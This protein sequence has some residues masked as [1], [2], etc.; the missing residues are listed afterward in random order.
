VAMTQIPEF[1]LFGDGRVVVTG[2]V[3]AIFPGPAMPPLLVRRLSESGMQTILQMV[4]QT[5]LFTQNREL[6]G[7][8]QFVA[9]AP[10]TVF[11]LHA[12]GR[13]VAISVYAL[14][15]W[16]DEPPRGV[17]AAELDAHRALVSLSERL[18]NLDLRADAWKDAG[19]EAFTPAAWRLFVRNADAD[20][21][22]PSGIANQLV[23][24]PAA[25]DA[26]SFGEPSVQQMRCGIV[27]GAV[28]QAW[29][30]ALMRAN[31]L[32]RFTSSGHHY[33]VQPRALLPD[34]ARTCPRAAA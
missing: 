13:E 17:T 6:N 31:Q 20:A 11:T 29:F 9:D 24:W 2:A 3:A 1:S 22:D 12:D 34:E 32:T 10:T 26:A 28:A 27:T 25:T 30:T 14:G 18:T 7:A 21:P 23:A 4:A 5:G 15:M 33:Q 16:G 19:W 8:L